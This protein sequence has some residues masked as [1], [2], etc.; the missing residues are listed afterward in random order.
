MARANRAA[1]RVTTG[2]APPALPAPAATWPMVPL[3]C[4]RPAA[5]SGQAC[6]PMG[7]TTGNTMACETALACTVSATGNQC[8]ACGGVG[9]PCCGTNNAGTCTAGLA[10]GGRNAGAGTPGMCATCGG[11]GQLCCPTGGAGVD[12]GPPPTACQTA[13]SCILAAAGNSCG[14]CGGAGQPCCGTVND[15]TCGASLACGGR[16]A[17]MGLPG[18][19]AACGGAGQLC[20]PVIGRASTAA[21]ARPRAEPRCRAWSRRPAISAETVVPRANRAAGRA[22]TEPARRRV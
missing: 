22:T 16:N 7:G 18:M 1:G 11:T 15:G 3:G 10:C 12:G 8:A 6:C 19:C 21:R 14:T 5:E 17:G 20:C 4:A 9:Q 13:L 2:P